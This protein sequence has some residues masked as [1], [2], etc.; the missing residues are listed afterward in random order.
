MECV[1]TKNDG[2]A[3]VEGEAS[4]KGC[5]YDGNHAECGGPEIF[6]AEGGKASAQRGIVST[7]NECEAFGLSYGFGIPVL[8]ICILG[9]TQ[10]GGTDMDFALAWGAPGP[11]RAR[12]HHGH[13]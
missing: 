1:F 13:Q 11:E 5:T 7:G 2:V 3:Y 6:Q 12:P 10:R 8:C 9:L 4:F